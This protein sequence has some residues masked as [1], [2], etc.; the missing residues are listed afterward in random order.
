MMA[1]RSALMALSVACVSLAA[2]GARAEERDVLLKSAEERQQEH[3]EREQRIKNRLDATRQ[4]YER[5]RRRGPATTAKTSAADRAATDR[6]AA[7][8]RLFSA[9]PPA[10]DGAL[11]AFH[12]ALAAYE[13]NRAGQKLVVL[14]IGDSHTAGDH[15]TG[16]L[17]ERFQR[18]FGDGGRGHL[19]AGTP[20]RWYDPY[21]V[22]VGQTAGW[23]VLSARFSEPAKYGL[24]GFTLK[25]DGT[26]AA[27]ERLE[28]TTHGMRTFTRVEIEYLSAA[29]GGGFAVFVDTKE[30]RKV[31]TK[32]QEGRPQRL[33]LD[34]P[35]PAYHVALQPTGDGPLTLLGV[36]LLNG[37]G[38]AVLVS[39][40]V[41][42]ETVKV[43]SRYDRA[44]TQWQ[45]Q[46]L[47]PALVLVAFGTNEGFETKFKP[48]EY[49]AEF[50]AQIEAIKQMA[51]NASLVVIGPPDVVRL[52]SW[53]GRTTAQREKHECRVLAKDHAAD[54]HRLIETKSKA[55]CY[56]HAPP[57]LAEVRAIQ[58][59]V[60]AAL[61][62]YFW[63]WSR[64]MGGDCGMDRWARANPPL[65][66]DR[67]HM[68]LA[69]YDFS[70][71]TLFRELVRD[72][73]RQ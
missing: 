37:R 58:A 33:V 27:G 50:K 28:Y 70:A 69:G 13:R 24:A 30:V 67:V 63:D 57:A 64:V 9:P 32:G 60:A 34:L 1:A 68:K 61:G 7:S 59:R 19:A 73:R 38:G 71:E 3:D 17:R 40:G 11:A 6:A 10:R 43:L 56:F 21:Q 42:G 20:Y 55:L 8:A 66:G 26:D 35:Q 54:Y 45:I 22:R 18:Q 47:N 15:F 46:H 41:G 4:L 2:A 65:T 23:Q 39:H 16:Y 29:N 52:P 51:P 72:Y 53:C 31:A 14:Q 36:S 49:E 12:R 62:A 44:V 5:E 48:E 25:L